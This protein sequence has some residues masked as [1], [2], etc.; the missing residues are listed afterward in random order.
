MPSPSTASAAR[1]LAAAGAAFSWTLRVYYEDTDAAGIVYYANF[2]KFFERCRTEWLRALGWGQ[3]ELALH[4]GVQ[5]VVT[6]VQI[7]Y[8]L[9]ARLDDELQIEA[10]VA[11]LRRASLDFEQR[12]LRGNDEL[13]SGRVAVAAVSV[14]TGAAIRLPT[15][16]VAAL[17]GASGGSHLDQPVSL[18]SP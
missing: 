16:L 15:Q 7:D 2:L 14:R 12:A 9:P 11:S 8:R 1:A 4:H 13:A 6:T 3:R 10:R 5:F 17:G 18:R